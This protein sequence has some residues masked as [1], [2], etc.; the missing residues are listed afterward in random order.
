M[1]IKNVASPT[2][3]RTD[4]D[5]DLETLASWTNGKSYL[6]SDGEEKHLPIIKLMIFS[7]NIIFHR[8]GS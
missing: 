3:N 6:V 2:F 1:L 4:A 7:G 5:V 8:E